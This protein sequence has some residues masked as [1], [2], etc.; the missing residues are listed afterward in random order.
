MTDSLVTCSFCE[1]G[2]SEV[3][4]LIVNATTRVGICDE[5]VALSLNIIRWGDQALFDQIVARAVQE[6]SKP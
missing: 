5:C 6:N 1:K 3:K 4:R 2:S